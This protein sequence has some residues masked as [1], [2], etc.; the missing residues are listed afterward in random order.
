MQPGQ[1]DNSTESKINAWYAAP[2]AI[3]GA[4]FLAPC[5]L[6][7]VNK[8]SP[9]NNWAL[10]DD[11]LKH[12]RKKSVLSK[13]IFDSHAKQLGEETV[14]YIKENKKIHWSPIL[15]KTGI[16]AA[17]VAGIYAVSALAINHLEKKN[18]TA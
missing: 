4:T 12:F 8:I 3:I 13:D 5:E 7:Y 11:V 18:K 6:P 16:C 9:M 1:V 14:K 15:K 2:A 10:Q 17:I